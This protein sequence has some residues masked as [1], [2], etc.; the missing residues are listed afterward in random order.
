MQHHAKPGTEMTN[1]RDTPSHKVV[2]VLLIFENGA[3]VQRE[4]NNTGFHVPFGFT[5][6]NDCITV[7][8]SQLIPLC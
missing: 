2:V 1:D 3:K 6:R 5:N 7:P 8:L 4:V